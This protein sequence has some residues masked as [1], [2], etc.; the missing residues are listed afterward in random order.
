[1]NANYRK[2]GAAFVL[3]VLLVGCVF[4]LDRSNRPAA[5]VPPAYW[6]TDGWQTAAPEAQGMDSE[7]LAQMVEHIQKEQLNLHS[8]LIVRN[9]YLVGELY[10]HPYS[11]GQP[12][13]IASV[14][15]SVVGALVGVAIS[16]G[17]I[18][19]VHQ[20]LFS[21][22]SDETVSNLDEN[23]KGITLEDLLTLT[24][25]LDCNENPGPGQ[26]F[27]EASQNWV[28]FMLDLPMAAPHGT[29]F[30]YCSGVVHLLSAVL[31]KAAGMNAR[32]FANQNLFSPLG[33]DPIS[34][35]RWPSDPQG[36]STGGYGLALT[37]QEMAKFGFL[38]LNQG[39]WDGKT[40]LPADWVTASTTSHTQKDDGK[41]YGYLW[42]IDPR[43][44]YY[45]ALG[46]AGQHIFVLPG[47]NLV[48]VFTAGLP[49]TNNADLIPLQELLDE[50][51]LPAIKSDRPLPANPQALARIEA[52]AQALAQ[53]RQAP[54]PLPPIALE[55]SGKTFTLSDNP[56][57]W[58]TIA[59]HFENG[60]E[61]AGITIDNAQ[62]L[63]V[64]LDN[65]FRMVNGGDSLF[66]EGLRGRWDDQDQLIVDAVL[67]GQLADFDNTIQFTSDSIRIIRRDKYSGAETV[68]NGA[69]SNG[70]S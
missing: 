12:H 53:P 4:P 8:L 10:A 32:D 59:F 52:G 7:I 67:V 48:V 55:I 47:K 70:G 57:G 21:Y 65:L 35:S 69:A 18:K 2:L 14:T 66:P 34:E 42:T 64:G 62:H 51:I 17:T 13:W 11:A 20:P 31:Q 54:Q 9:G 37:P 30:S 25:G 44:E 5:P 60:A 16:Q 22:L 28:D 23:K 3:V 68:I 24:A 19:D 56:F 29:R 27:M 39:K 26:P 33:I 46:R 43:G 15:K 6:P 50:Y 58:H 63:E 38:F 1:M 45:C 40:I 41:G 49:Y 36:V 61:V